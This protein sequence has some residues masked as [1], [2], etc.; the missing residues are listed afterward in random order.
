M[1]RRTTTRVCTTPGCPNL[2]PCPQHRREPWADSD[3][4][5][6]LPP[7]WPRR[8]ANTLRRD[9]IC[10]LNLPG[11]TTISTEAD[12]AGD[13]DDHDNLRG[14]CASC[15]RKRTLQQAAEGRRRPPGG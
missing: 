4:R 7:D 5:A 10:T 6:T 8:R 11:C 15:H 14:A 1:S 3:R 2:Q 9:P 13:R 12:H